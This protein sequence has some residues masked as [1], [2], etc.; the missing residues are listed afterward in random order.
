[1]KE[2]YFAILEL[3]NKEKI[4]KASKEEKK[5]KYEGT[6]NRHQDSNMGY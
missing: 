6:K 5:V 1:M 2:Y 4:W 3:K